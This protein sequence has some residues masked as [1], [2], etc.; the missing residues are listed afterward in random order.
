MIKGNTNRGNI[1][2]ENNV[3]IIGGGPI[4]L[5]TGLM[6]AK[7]KIK[8]IIV[9]KRKNVSRKQI[10]IINNLVYESLPNIVKKNL[11]EHDSGSGCFVL[12]AAQ[13]NSDY[14]CFRKRTNKDKDVI[15]FAS[16]RID[17]LQSE[18][19][20]YVQ[21]LNEKIPIELIFGEISFDM[22][23]NLAYIGK[24]KIKYNIL[25]GA[26]GSNS[27][28]RDK[29]F[30]I[31]KDKAV[32]EYRDLKKFQHVINRNYFMKDKQTTYYYPLNATSNEMKKWPEFKNHTV[33]A[34]IKLPSAINKKSTQ[35]IQSQLIQSRLTSKQYDEWQEKH[36][37]TIPQHHYRF[38]ITP[39]NSAY[40]AMTLSPSEFKTSKSNIIKKIKNFLYEL[41]DI[42]QSSIIIDPND[43]SFITVELY[44]SRYFA[45]QLTPHSIGFL[46]GD[47]AFNTHYFTGNGLNVGILMATKLVTLITQFFKKSITNE[48]MIRDY[49]VYMNESIDNAEG[50]SYEIW[51]DYDNVKRVCNQLSSNDIELFQKRFNIKIPSKVSHRNKCDI[52]AYAIYS[53]E[54]DIFGKNNKIREMFRNELLFDELLFDELSF[55]ENSFEDI[56]NRR[57]AL[58][59]NDPKTEIDRLVFLQLFPWA[60]IFII[61]R[62]HPLNFRN[63][64]I[65]LDKLSKE[66]RTEI[67]KAI[68]PY[69][70]CQFSKSQTVDWETIIS[71]MSDV[72]HV[73]MNSLLIEKKTITQI[74]QEIQTDIWYSGFAAVR[75]IKTECAKTM[76]YDI[77]SK[78][79]PYIGKIQKIY[80][81]NIIG[82][83]KQPMKVPDF[84]QKYHAKYLNRDI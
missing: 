64:Y 23:K 39:T 38:F 10:L 7:R 3:L 5:L 77:L 84:Y 21:S 33:I 83:P 16:V 14:K 13:A 56:I 30:K 8:T 36:L 18:L 65:S 15:P 12:P 52:L 68:R 44:R 58:K 54:Y 67:E 11:F 82:F 75:H 28:M 81:K 34:T 78:I 60:K 25:I 41:Y 42:P 72:F 53:N 61:K 29:I 43:V 70:K 24:R 57:A 45:K 27:F 69:L 1:I 63:Q 47:A 48:N 20:K 32:Y 4:G 17:K 9:E 51:V 66:K 55:D 79:E 80:E 50:R 22:E 40:I 6:L 73:C 49:D 62:N 74:K 59:Y 26:D 31:P 46:V 19:V 37:K 2:K 71:W 76:F 35:L